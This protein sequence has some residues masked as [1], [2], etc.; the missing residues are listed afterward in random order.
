MGFFL[1]VLPMLKENILMFQ[2]ASPH[3]HML[4]EK[5]WSLLKNFLSCFVKPEILQSTGRSSKMIQ[6]L[7][8]EELSNHLPISSIFEGDVA[9]KLIVVS[10]KFQL[11]VIRKFK[12]STLKAYVGCAKVLVKKAF[13]KPLLKICIYPQSFL[14]KTFFIFEV[15]ERTS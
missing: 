14:Q 10:P 3:I 8:I 15:N 9:K 12:S 2:A 6:N 7:K 11:E 1:A 4:Y 5:Q 13:C